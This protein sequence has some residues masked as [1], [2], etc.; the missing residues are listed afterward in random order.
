[1]K[2][3]HPFFDRP[4]LDVAPDL[5]GKVVVRRLG[6]ETL[7]GRIVET[8]AYLDHPDMASHASRK[9]PKRAQI[10]FGPPGFAYVYQ[11]YGMYFCLN[12]VAEREGVAGAVLVRAAEPVEGIDAIK[13][14]RKRPMPERNLTS[15]PSKLCQAL[16]I[17]MAFNGVDLCGDE[18]WVEDRGLPRG[19]V[20]T[21]P[22]VGVDYAGEWALKPWRFW[23]AGSPFVSK[24]PRPRARRGSRQ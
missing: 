24:A 18:L 13:R 12:L 9:N 4:T 21:G 10:M 20:C 17:D 2:L 14:L 3:A 5:L 16:G 22:R 8:E 6:N 1:M 7:A 11:V 19:E 23:E 15:G